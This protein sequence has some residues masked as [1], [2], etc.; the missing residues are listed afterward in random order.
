[1]AARRRR[2]RWSS[3]VRPVRGRPACRAACRIRTSESVAIPWPKAL[4]GVEAR[5]RKIERGSRARR[6]AFESSGI[7]AYIITMPDA[8]HVTNNRQPPMRR[9]QRWVKTHRAAPINLQHLPSVFTF[10]RSAKAFALRQSPSAFA[11]LNAFALRSARRSDLRDAPINPQSA[12][13]NPHCSVW[14]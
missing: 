10:S 14:R 3:R 5:C 1:M 2:R 13:P 9:G 11:R 8:N 4:P 7:R 6:S 12:I